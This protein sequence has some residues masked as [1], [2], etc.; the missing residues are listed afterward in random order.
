M[1]S[2]DEQF[3]NVFN[4]HYPFE[5]YILKEPKSIFNLFDDAVL[6][7][8]FIPHTEIKPVLNDDNSLLCW[9]KIDEYQIYV[10]LK[11]KAGE[12]R[13]GYMDFN[14]HIRENIR[15]IIYTDFGDYEW[16]C[17]YVD[18]EDMDDLNNLIALQEKL[19]KEKYQVCNR[20]F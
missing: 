16:E 17:L 3:I 11:T 18:Y 13:M 15:D 8:I 19:I 5:R 20:K 6:T 10:K 7:E 14:S 4:D 2:Y 1:D 9:T 12:I